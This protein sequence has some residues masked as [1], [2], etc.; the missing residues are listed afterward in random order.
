MLRKQQEASNR[1]ESMFIKDGKEKQ[2]P[3][4]QLFTT[5]K[6]RDALID[7]GET[8]NPKVMANYTASIELQEKS[9]TEYELS[10]LKSAYKDVAHYGR[11]ANIAQAKMKV[12]FYVA[13]ATKEGLTPDENADYEKQ[14]L[15]INK[16][17][18]E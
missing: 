5:W 7:S 18:G 14:K 12:N 13:K 2:S 4:Y 15:I 16:S 3:A 8:L 10:V 1:A 9:F 17:K 6:E 11:E